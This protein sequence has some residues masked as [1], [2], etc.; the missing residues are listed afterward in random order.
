MGMQ[1]TRFDRWLRKKFVHEL[2]IYSLRPADMLPKNVH[3]EEMPEAPGRLYRY[4]YVTRDEKSA[5]TIIQNF[6]ANNQMFATRIVDRQDPLAKFITRPDRSVAWMF[7]WICLSVVIGFGV[8]Q[9]ARVIQQNP[10]FQ[11]NFQEAIEIMKG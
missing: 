8:R 10:E 5:D 6:K 11:R 1:L 7:L 2:H 9:V 3:A 4:H